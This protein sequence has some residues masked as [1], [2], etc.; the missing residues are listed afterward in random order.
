MK[1]FFGHMHTICIC[2]CSTYCKSDVMHRARRFYETNSIILWSLVM[3]IVPEFCFTL[4]SFH[5]QCHEKKRQ[6]IP[7][8]YLVFFLLFFILHFYFWWC[9]FLWANIFFLFVP[10]NS[11]GWV[12][13]FCMC[14]FF[15]C[16]RFVKVFTPTNDFCFTSYNFFPTFFCCHAFIWKSLWAFI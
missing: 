14:I 16:F 3:A 6:Q 1:T 10:F 9:H 15:C 8:L 4:I 11:F 7:N 12:V 2:E 13:K 5:H